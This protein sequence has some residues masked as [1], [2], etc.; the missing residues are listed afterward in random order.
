MTRILLILAFAATALGGIPG[1][2]A[3]RAAALPSVAVVGTGSVGSTL[4]PRLAEAGYPVV[5]GSRN[6]D[7]GAV[8]ELVASTGHGARAT[9]PKRATASAELIILAVPWSAVEGLLLSFGD[10]TGKIII[11][12]INAVRFRNREIS[13]ATPTMAETIAR[14]APGAHVV[15][16]LNTTS[17][18]YMRDPEHPAGTVS[19]PMAGNDAAAKQ[20]VTRMIE[21]LGFH[22]V[23]VGPLANAVYL[24][25]MGAL[26]IHMNAI[27]G[28]RGNFEYRIL[29]KDSE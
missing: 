25:A 20:T 7:S 27:Q 29:Q 17:A 9:T 15:K 19:M 13:L 11:D 26:Y 16:T 22:A 28:K 6:P 18:I 8:K 12:P 23:D 21:T 10:L 14:L 1:H 5:Y 24:E 3:D 2:A 4:G